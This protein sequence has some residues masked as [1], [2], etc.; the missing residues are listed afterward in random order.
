MLHVFSCLQS[1]S[2]TGGKVVHEEWAP[3]HKELLG[4]ERSVSW[5][6]VVSEYPR[7]QILAGALDSRFFENDCS[8]SA[9]LHDDLC[10][11][12]CV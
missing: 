4:I 10:G 2:C 12:A 1:I 3:V 9:L 5:K 6:A 11:D 7:K 8:C